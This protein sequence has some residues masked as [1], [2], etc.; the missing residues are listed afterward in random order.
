MNDI[1]SLPN[2]SISHILCYFYIF[3]FLVLPSNVPYYYNQIVPF[4]LLGMSLKPYAS[5]KPSLIVQARSDPSGFWLLPHPL[6]CDLHTSF[7]GVFLML[8]G[9]YIFVQLNALE[10]EGQYILCV[11]H[12]VIWYTIV[13]TQWHLIIIIIVISIR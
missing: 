7:M 11:I 2:S 6:E 5:I 1:V 10:W 9:L 3:Q 8:V 13:G 4:L 12:N